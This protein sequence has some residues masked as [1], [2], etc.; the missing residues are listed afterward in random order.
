MSQIVNEKTCVWLVREGYYAQ[1]G[2]RRLCT[3]AYDQ[4]A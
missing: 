2:E 1:C 3:M 4:K